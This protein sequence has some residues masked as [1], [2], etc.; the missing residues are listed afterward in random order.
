MNIQPRTP[1]LGNPLLLAFSSLLSPRQGQ[2]TIVPGMPAP[3]SMAIVGTLGA[4]VV[5]LVVLKK[6]RM[7]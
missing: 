1:E 7:I 6:K 5:L 3:L 2:T 4:A